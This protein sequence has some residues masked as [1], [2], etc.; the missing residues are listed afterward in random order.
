MER[1]LSPRLPVC[2]V[3]M[4]PGL[5]QW[6]LSMRSRQ[7]AMTFRTRGGTRA[8]AGRPAKG[9][10]GIRHDARTRVTPSAP[11]HV[12][13][14]TTQRVGNLRR[15]DVYAAIRA[16]TTVAAR[17]AELHIVHLS[18]QR[19][20]LHLIVEAAS[21]PALT[22][23]LRSFQISAAMQINGVLSARRSAASHG[24]VFERYHARSLATPRQVRACL[25]YVLNNW[26]H[27]DEHRKPSAAHWLVDK[28]SSAIAFDGWKELGAG[29]RF[30]APADHAPLTVWPPRCWLLRVGWTRYGLVAIREIPS[31]RAERGQSDPVGP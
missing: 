2:G 15:P 13:V 1:G 24:S 20:H 31:G 26:R 3:Q 25:S 9:L 8:G 14:R 23:G 11:L 30:T 18:I 22:K 17:H 7:T 16:A 29:G 27:H 10:H 6:S 21:G 5:N 12:V 4:E 19:T 28:Y